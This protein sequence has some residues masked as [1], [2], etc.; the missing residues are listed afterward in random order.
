MFIPVCNEKSRRPRGHRDFVL[1]DYLSSAPQDE[2][3]AEGFGSSPEAPHDEGF[4]SSSEA[5]HDEGF[6]FWSSLPQEEP[7][8]VA[9]NAI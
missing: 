5:P 3:Q 8:P 4:G 6:G 2:P 9:A 7:Q 1:T